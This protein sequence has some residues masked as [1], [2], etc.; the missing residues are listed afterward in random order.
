[1][2][3]TTVLD[4]AGAVQVSAGGACSC[5]LL[6]DGSPW[7]WGTNYAGQL[8][9]GTKTNRPS[10]VLIAT[11]KKVLEVAAGD[12]HACA[13]LEDA[14]VACWGHNSTGELGDGTSGAGAD[15]LVP[16][17]VTG[18]TGAVDI[19]IGD[20]QSCAVLAT[21]AV[22]CWG[23]NNTGQLGDGTTT[24]A[25]TPVSVM[26]ITNAQ[27]IEGGSGLGCAYLTTGGVRCWGVNNFGQLGDGTKK[28]SKT[29]VTP[30]GLN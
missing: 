23:L 10:P 30:T 15:K 16:T 13:R 5:A 17:A 26:N 14:T 7:C 6:E 2:L 21:G 20:A 1:V 9:D 11:A 4:L 28:N 18:L 19:G 29:P 27:L 22:K 24:D 3:P 12:L 25:K 8:G